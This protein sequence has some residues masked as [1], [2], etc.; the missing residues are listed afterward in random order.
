MSVDRPDPAPRE[1]DVPVAPLAADGRSGSSRAPILAA[2]AIFGLVLAA[3]GL[4]RVFPATTDGPAVTLPSTPG[5]AAAPASAAATAGPFAI[6]V[7]PRLRAAQLVEGVLDG[8][9]DGTLVYADAFLR[10][11]CRPEES[12]ACSEATLAIDGLGLDVV[13]VD[14]AHDEV[15]DVPEHGLLVLV[16][17]GS[18][19]EYLGPLTVSPTGSPPLSTLAPATQTLYDASGWLVL[20]PACVTAGGPA[21]SNAATRCPE[22]PPFLAE[23]EPSRGGILRSDAGEVVALSPSLWGVDT[24]DTVTEGPFLVAP[25]ARRGAS[26]GDRRALRPV[27]LGARG[28][29]VSPR[30]GHP[31]SGVDRDRVRDLK[32][33][34]DAR[35]AAEH[36]RSAALLDRGRA[37][38]PN[39]VP[40]AW[41]RGSYHHLPMWIAEGLG[42]HITDVDGHTYADFNI[43]DL[44]MF[45]GYAPEPLVRA[46]SE[47]VA[48]GNQFLLPTEDSIVVSEELGRR[49]G[50]PMW[51]YTSSATHAN[52]EAIRVA[53]VVTGRDRVLMF[54]GKYHGHLDEA[55]V[56]LGATGGWS[57]RSAACPPTPSTARSSSR[58]TTSGRWSG[59]SSG[60]TSRSCS[61]NPRSRTT[62]ACCSPTTGS[63]PRSA[64]SPARRAR[65]SRTTRRTPR[66]SG[67]AGSCGSGVSSP[68]SSPSASPSRA[69]S[70]S[71]HG[72]RP[73]R[74]RPCSSSTRART[75]SGST[76]SPPA[77]RSSATRSRWRLPAP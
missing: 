74:S 57:R 14:P 44:S 63:M 30:A 12:A 28:D 47:R 13:A 19:L 17:Q 21:A 49:F 64:A 42:A 66:W 22:R 43:A 39:G 62:S 27:A 15:T 61:P 46:V 72:E 36:P 26:L 20:D 7:A 51:Q 75:G 70:R 48:R 2:V 58:S 54:D 38:M 68:T 65:S 32:Q 4:A 11:S 59:R 31:Q 18:R 60:G 77:A 3:I 10:R 24:A 56:E 33:A 52:T 8:S 23:D 6:P 9:L 34:E 45:C 67:R 41:M 16:V 69:A 71:G 53:R 40:M 35:F 50:L 29:P 73:T 37:V 1:L 55:L 25:A 76:S 5:V